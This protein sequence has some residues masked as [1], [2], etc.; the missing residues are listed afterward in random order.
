[1]RWTNMMSVLCLA[2]MLA[3]VTGAF[4][5]SRDVKN[6]VVTPSS[7]RLLGFTADQEE[8]RFGGPATGTDHS[9][10]HTWENFKAWFKKTFFFWRKRE[11]TRRLRN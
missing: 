6:G 9:N 8:R 1:M 4:E 3:M 5:T 10:S 2:L 11:Q 7:R